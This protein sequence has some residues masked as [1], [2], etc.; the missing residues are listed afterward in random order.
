[1]KNFFFS[2]IRTRLIL[3]FF[4]ALVPIILL[5]AYNIR[6]QRARALE[7]ATE[8]ADTIFRF[9]VMNEQRL[10][11]ETRELLERLSTDPEIV[12]GEKCDAYLSSILPNHPRF[13]NFGLIRPDGYLACSAVPFER[14]LF[15]GDRTFF[16][17]VVENRTFTIG[18][19]LVGRITGTP[20]ITF[21]YPVFDVRKALAGVVFA[22]LDLSYVTE[23]EAEVSGMLPSGSTFVKIDAGGTVIGGIPGSS[24]YRIGEPLE[25]SVFETIDRGKKG[26]FTS[27]DSDGVERLHMYSTLWGTLYGHEAHVLLGIPTGTLLSESGKA[28]ERSFGILALVSAATVLL[29]WRGGE[30]FV[31]EPV[32]RIVE[33]SRRLARG[34][35]S[36]RADLPR[37]K[38]EIGHL[39]RAF[40]DMACALERNSKKLSEGRARLSQILAASPAVIYAYRLPPDGGGEDGYPVFLSD[41]IKDLLG[42]EPG[43]VLGERG[44]AMKNV[45]PEDAGAAT[46]Q[47][48]LLRD[49]RS[50]VEYRLRAKGGEYRWV[51]DQ[52]VLVRDAGGVPLEVVGSLTDITDRKRAEEDLVRLGMAVEQAAEGFIV[53]GATGTVEYVN[54]AF[55]KITGYSSSEVIGRDIRALDDERLESPYHAEAEETLRKGRSWNGR[56]IARRKDGAVYTEDAVISPVRDRT[57]AIVKVVASIR[58]VTQEAL[59]QKQLQIAQRMEAVGTLAGGIAHDFN[60]ALTGIFGFTEIALAKAGGNEDVVASLNEVRRCADRAALLTRQL[61]AYSRRQVINPVNLDLNAVITDLMKLVAKIVGA[62][63]RIRTVLGKGLPT[64]FADV[65]QVEQVLMNLVINS[66]DAMPA[67][68]DL[69]IETGV[70]DAGEEYVARHPFMKAGRYVVLSVADTG[71]GMDEKTMERVFDPFFSTKG[72]DK[73]TGLGLAMVYGIVKQHKGYISLESELGKGTVFRIF[74]PPVDSPPDAA[75][76]SGPAAIPR[77]KET[78]LVAEDDEAVRALVKTTLEELGYTVLAAGGGAEAVALLE[79]EPGAVSLA[80]LDV[81]MPKMGGKEA[82]RAM[83]RI[84]PGLKAVLMSGY[85]DADAHESL[86]VPP[87]VPLLPKPFTPAELARKVREVLDAPA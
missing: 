20:L 18:E 52:R 77:G 50:S 84:S 48:G 34:D 13:I 12:R 85:A 69:L 38:G 53:T 65:G 15:M 45:H 23:F 57:G 74:L 10:L 54:P 41:R 62:Q 66:R 46:D 33:A 17:G 47:T 73:G 68:G 56:R 60:N 39:G 70:M 43:E 80:L 30:R 40:D 35:L 21:G 16:R 58:D 25:D 7:Q 64:V 31:V 83:L 75:A 72:P 26:S 27:V 71:V 78:V 11:L 19:Y 59:L 3:I 32:T 51:L 81:V 5:I 63:V 29:L 36:A 67:G 44:W 49:G 9:A 4:V 79:R 22:G 76:S 1:M 6:E 14:P 37:E 42:Y 87:Q 86:A 55:G 82:Y 2:S 8:K 24:L 61:L 28:L